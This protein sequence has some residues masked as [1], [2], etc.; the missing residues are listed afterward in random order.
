VIPALLSRTP[1]N[2]RLRLRAPTEAQAFAA[3]SPRDGARSQREDTPPSTGVKTG[4]GGELVGVVVAA[5]DRRADPRVVPVAGLR[6]ALSFWCCSHHQ[7]K[8]DVTE[9]REP[10]S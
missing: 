4:S 8:L 5:V 7:R 3:H 10:K 9:R 2:L 1:V 6:A